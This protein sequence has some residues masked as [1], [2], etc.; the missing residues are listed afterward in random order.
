[1]YWA[2]HSLAVSYCSRLKIGSTGVP[3]VWSFAARTSALAIACS[4]SRR[5]DR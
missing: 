2:T 4:S 3:T 1:M 5:F